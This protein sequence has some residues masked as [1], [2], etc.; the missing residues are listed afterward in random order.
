MAPRSFVIAS[1]NFSSSGLLSLSSN[2]FWRLSRSRSRILS[3]DSFALENLGLSVHWSTP[4]P[5]LSESLAD[6]MGQQ[7]CMESFPTA[8][9]CHVM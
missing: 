7:S 1:H 4:P 9:S 5:H 3:T 2:F 6:E 8:D